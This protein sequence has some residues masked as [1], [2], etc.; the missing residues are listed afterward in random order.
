MPGVHLLIHCQARGHA[1]VALL[2][3]KIALVELPS[4]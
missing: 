4:D 3:I 1:L 2:D